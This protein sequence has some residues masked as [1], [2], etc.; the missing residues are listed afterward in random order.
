M[1]EGVRVV[2]TELYDISSTQI[3]E[4]LKRGECVGEWLDGGVEEYI[5]EKGLYK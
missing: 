1:P 2:D 5:R 3:R 4:S